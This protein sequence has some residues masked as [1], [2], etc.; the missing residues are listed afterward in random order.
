[1]VLLGRAEAE[2]RRARS[3]PGSGDRDHGLW[4]RFQES[5]DT[6]RNSGFQGGQGGQLSRQQAKQGR[7]QQ[8]EKPRQ[9]PMAMSVVVVLVLVIDIVRNQQLLENFF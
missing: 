4:R 2:V 1:M 6:M 7:R 3:R 8:Q 5:L 9:D